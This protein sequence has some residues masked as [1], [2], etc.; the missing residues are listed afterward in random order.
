[1]RIVGYF[2]LQVLFFSSLFQG[3]GRFLIFNLI[4]NNLFKLFTKLL[5]DLFGY[6]DLDFAMI[7]AECNRMRL[8]AFNLFLSMAEFIT[9]TELLL[10]A[11]LLL[12]ML[13]LSL[14]FDVL[15]KIDGLIVA[16]LTIDLR[17]RFFI[18]IRDI[19]AIRTG[20]RVAILLDKTV[21]LRI[22]F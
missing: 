15:F 5:S 10:T 3:L 11:V 20:I 14:H 12:R 2:F 16:V 19:C 17:T 21:I 13:E 8:L 9:I 7:L 4:F 1:M 22:F 18:L 6:V